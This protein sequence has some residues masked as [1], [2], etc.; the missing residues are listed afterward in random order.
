MAL[1]VE[2]K[3]AFKTL[4]IGQQFICVVTENTGLLI[5]EQNVAIVATVHV[6]ENSNQTGTISLST[7][8]SVP[9]SQ[10]VCIFDFGAVIENYVTPDY[11]GVLSASPAAASTF[12]DVAYDSE[13]G[14][15]ALHNI[16]R[17]CYGDNTVAYGTVYFELEFLG[18]NP[19]TPNIVGFNAM[20]SAIDTLLIY[21]GVLYQTDPL[22]YKDLLNP[23]YGYDLD[24][25]GYIN[26][27]SGS[28]FMTDMPKTLYARPEDYGTVALLNGLNKQNYS[29]QTYVSTLTPA[30]NSLNYLEYTWYNA[31]GLDGS[32]KIYNRQSTGGWNGVAPDLDYPIEAK[33]RYLFAGIYPANLRATEAAFEAALTTDM[34]YYTVQGFS[35]SVAAK[36]DLY[37]VNIIHDCQYEPIRL[38][39][40]NKHG[41]WDYY[42]FKKKSVRTLTSKRTNYQKLDGTWN[43]KTFNPNVNQGGMKS[44][45]VKTKEAIKINTDFI[46]EEESVWLEQLMTTSEVFLLKDYFVGGGL[47]VIRKFNEPVLIK[48]SSYI[49]KTVANDKLIQYT[50]EIEKSF[51]IKTQGA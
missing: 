51:E 32:V 31:A 13:V 7:Y 46:S 12:H 45:K 38:A 50:F 26:N 47:E 22:S 30:L 11:N 2:Q 5:S 49:K 3:P 20:Y 17:Y 48:T 42:T 40:L 1:V 34:L 35:N 10:G 28:T 44:F 19:L 33:V 15:H 16:D 14:Y 29:F 8:K 41:A 39:W 36:T 43:A 23:D 9:N 4:P 21:N 6:F 18:G 25:N 37:T 27:D 24:L